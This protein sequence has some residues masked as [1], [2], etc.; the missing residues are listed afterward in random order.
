ML[1]PLYHKIR[2]PFE[3]ILE[4][5]DELNTYAFSKITQDKTN[6]YAWDIHL[7][8]IRQLKIDLQ[9][10]KNNF[11]LQNLYQDLKLEILTSSL[12]R[13]IWVVKAYNREKKTDDFALY[14]DATEMGNSDFLLFYLPNDELA[15]LGFLNLLLS[16]VNDNNSEYNVGNNLISYQTKQIFKHITEEK[17]KVK[18]DNIGDK[19]E[20]ILYTTI[21]NTQ[22]PFIRAIIDDSNLKTK[23]TI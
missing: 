13:Y 11:I 16:I 18:T 2:I 17:I 4:I 1:I 3:K 14:F 19:I 21:K 8:T 9:T 5:T 12:P 15:Y 22:D 6:K 10:K 20:T 7:T 23:K